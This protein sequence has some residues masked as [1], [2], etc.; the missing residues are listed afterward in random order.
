MNYETVIGLEVHAELSTKTKIYCGCTTEFGGDVNTHCC[1]VCLGL[2]GSLPKL[3]KKVVEYAI[4]AGLATNCSITRESFMARKNYFYPDCPKDY[5]IT[6]H[7][8][9]LCADGYIE[10]ET[11]EGPKKIRIERIHIE[12]DAG[13][14]LHS[15]DGSLVDYN[16]TGVPLIEI[17][18]R[19]DMRSPEEAVLY[20]EKLKSILQY[21][22]VS[23]CKMEEGS[24]RCDANISLRPMGQEE[25]GTKSEIKNMNSFKA[26]EKALEYEKQRHAE[27]LDAGEKIHQETRRWDDAKGVTMLM[28]SKEQAH[29]YRYFPEPDLVTLSVSDEWIE[30]VKSTLPELPDSRRKR[31]MEEYNLPEYDSEVLTAS[32]RLA[33]FFEECVKGYN[34]PKSASNWVM[35]EMMRLMN[36][37]NMGIEDIKIKPADLAELLSMIGKGTISGTIAKKVF[38]EMFDTGKKPK[39]IVQEKGLVQNSNLDEIRGIVLKVLS[40]NEQSVIDYKSGKT[41]AF[42][43][44][45]G[46]IMKASKGKANPAI[47]NGILK[48]ELDK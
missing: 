32:K 37:R 11:K 21:V 27:V 8:L 46:Q 36:D 9:P 38:A 26:L 3:N 34:D 28:R 1:P 40:E 2:P 7:E 30:N 35:G 22:E 10:I 47:V 15:G 44:L 14:L 24:L 45:V 23:D 29:D 5:Q 18:S 13:K 4:K 31:F 17:V 16:R 39:A 33:N 25:F 12:E 43:F 19:P 41:R 42:G 48:E 6:Q 20:L